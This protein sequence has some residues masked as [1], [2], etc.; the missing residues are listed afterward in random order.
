MGGNFEME[1]ANMDRE[2]EDLVGEGPENQQ[3]NHK[4]VCNYCKMKFN[5]QN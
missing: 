4:W 2:I 5:E 3:T 1:L